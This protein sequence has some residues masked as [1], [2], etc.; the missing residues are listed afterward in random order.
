MRQLHPVGWQERFVASG[1]YV[2]A[3][4]GAAT[5]ESEQWTIHELPDGA[6]LTRVERQNVTHHSFILV[7]AWRGRGAA[8]VER[9]DMQALYPPAP[10]IRASYHV[11]ADRLDYTFLSPAERHHSLPLPDS[12]IVDSSA[13]ILRGP[14]IAQAAH[15]GTVA[16]VSVDPG[17]VIEPRVVSVSVEQVGIE[18]LTLGAESIATRVYNVAGMADML[19][20]LWLDEH[21]VALRQTQGSLTIQLNQYVRRPEPRHHD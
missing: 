4:D 17:D 6:R 12:A 21:D 7:E 19:T 16:L 9:F 5:G 11:A 18:T 2:Y 20:T 13:V 14:V 1:V 3:R 15:F 10:M 8:Y